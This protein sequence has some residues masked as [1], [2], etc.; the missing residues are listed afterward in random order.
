L[1]IYLVIYITTI[2]FRCVAHLYF[3]FSALHI[4]LFIILFKQFLFE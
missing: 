4:Q 2:N 1:E 3:L